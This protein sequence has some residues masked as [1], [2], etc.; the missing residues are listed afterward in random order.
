MATRLLTDRTTRRGFTLIEVALAVAILGVVAAGLMAASARM[1]RG[2]TQDRGRS[3]A[4]ASAEA[5]LALVRQWPDYRTL[6]SAFVGVESNTP[7]AGLTRT[8]T[9]ARTGGAN[10]AN[11]FKRI[12]VTVS[13]ASLPAPVSRTLAVAAP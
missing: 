3:V 7:I 8:T 9:I 11:D 10:Q 1:I 6:D 5:R 12:T 4:A 2:V 13:G